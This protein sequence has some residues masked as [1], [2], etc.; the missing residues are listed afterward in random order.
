MP[1]RKARFLV[2]GAVLLVAPWIGTT[3]GAAQV[4]SPGVFPLQGERRLPDGGTQYIYTV[5]GDQVT[6]NRPPV[7]F[8]PATATDTQ[9]AFYGFPPRPTGEPALD[10]WKQRM[11]TFHFAPVPNGL[12]ETD[13]DAGYIGTVY[14]NNWSG[15]R[16]DS[17]Q[18]S[19]RFAEA[20]YYEATVTGPPC[21]NDGV[22]EWTGL[23]GSGTLGQ[24]G[25]A[26]YVTGETAGNWF[27]Q[28][29]PNMEKAVEVTGQSAPGDKVEVSVSWAN[30]GDAY[31]F[32][33]YDYNY[34]SGNAIEV[35]GRHR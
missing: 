9:L 26:P 23:S 18:G 4:S 21:P 5:D 34:N 22:V 20:I 27:Y 31:F 7:G 29:K 14:S 10:G 12:H 1:G 35:V 16:A 8:N 11:Q 30:S 13:Y 25:T 17:S 6:M 24:A 19:Y 2:F 3:S 33:W 28:V 15:K 32:T